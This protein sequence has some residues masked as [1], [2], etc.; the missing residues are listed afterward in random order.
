MSLW[1][2]QGACELRARPTQRRTELSPG[3]SKLSSVRPWIV[4]VDV[5][6]GES[7]SRTDSEKPIDGFDAYRHELPASLERR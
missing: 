5:V 7:N 6:L 1:S 2:F 3:L 4:E